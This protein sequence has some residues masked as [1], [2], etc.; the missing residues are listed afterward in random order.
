MKTR[1]R[2]LTSLGI[3]VVGGLVACSGAD[4]PPPF[5]VGSGSLAS[6]L[7][8]DLGARVYL[9][10]TPG[11]P[12]ATTATTARVIAAGTTRAD[13]VR[14]FLAPYAAELGLD[15]NDLEVA[16]EGTDAAGLHHATVR[17]KHELAS[18]DRR[19]GIDVTT[20]GG[21]HF[22]ALAG[23]LYPKAMART[24]KV[25]GPAATAAVP[26]ATAEAPTLGVFASD[27]TTS[28]ADAALAYR[29]PT[30]HGATWIDASDGR[31]LGSE[32]ADMGIG[33]VA[34]SV[35]REAF[36]KSRAFYRPEA[37]KPI[38][39]TPTQTGY[40]LS[41]RTGGSDIGVFSL[42]GFDA[43]G[44]R[45]GAPITS[46]SLTEWDTSPI[47]YQ[48]SRTVGKKIEPHPLSSA[49]LAPRAAVDAFH[50]VALADTFFRRTFG[51][52]PLSG[53]DPIRVFVHANF[54]APSVG[55]DDT[56]E[57][58]QSARDNAT[59]SFLDRTISFGDGPY[60]YA[61][62]NRDDPQKRVLP[63]MLALDVVGHELSHAFGETTFGR[64]GEA[65][66]VNEG[67]ADVLGTIFES[68]ADPD[69]RP[70]VIGERVWVGSCV[71][72]I[73][74][75][76][77]RCKFANRV[78]V[79]SFASRGCRTPDGRSE[80]PTA[81]NDRGCIHTNA[82]IVGHAFYLMAYGG[83]NPV[84][85][86]TIRKPLSPDFA[87]AIGLSVHG[88]AMLS[89][90]VPTPNT[91]L[92]VARYQVDVAKLFSRADANTTACAWHAVGVLDRD[93]LTMLGFACETSPPPSCVG[94]EDGWYCDEKIPFA[95]NSCRGGSIASGHQCAS[96]QVC[97]TVQGSRKAK[98]TAGLPTCIAAP[99]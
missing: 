41:G 74:N 92:S 21:G 90:L 51:R 4:D 7:E 54:W 31:V 62:P 26:D 42:V 81:E 17:T 69:A 80:P 37:A 60:F 47:A 23:H 98:L 68:E 84:T 85:H 56:T 64:V 5:P 58:S 99:K 38:E 30:T 83:E 96:G 34:P 50:A 24:A 75:P 45:V 86:V 43:T 78:N 77:E 91:F 14:A 19:D 13:A 67:L 32:A 65:G 3:L 18:V 66:A 53:T 16:G 93:Y 8:Q 72:N 25:T 52:G 71:R 49:G 55:D 94:R 82:T 12:Y 95:A 57:A 70:D 39:V 40:T 29:V 15:P 2:L 1:S 87:K 63:T 48:G 9:D 27:G 46:Q 73:A 44:S 28:A 61:T 11:R 35:E 88:V 76:L 33:V 36:D 20:D 10:L 6:R 97:A 79:A 59:F 89:P 22:V